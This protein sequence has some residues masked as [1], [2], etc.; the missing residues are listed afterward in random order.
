MMISSYMRR[1][2]FPPCN[3]LVIRDEA[4]K[5]VRPGVKEGLNP[6]SGT[7]VSGVTTIVWLNPNKSM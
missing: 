7:T 2:Y 4:A 1:G 3:T 6:S 5:A